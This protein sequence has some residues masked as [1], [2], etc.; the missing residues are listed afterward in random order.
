MVVAKWMFSLIQKILPNAKTPPWTKWANTIR[1]M[2][3]QDGRT[4]AE[5]RDVFRRANQDDFWRANVLSPEKLRK[6]LGNGLELKLKR[7]PKQEPTSSPLPPL[8]NP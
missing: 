7:P 4:H 8:V 1:L 6:Q 3:E 2:R 5:I